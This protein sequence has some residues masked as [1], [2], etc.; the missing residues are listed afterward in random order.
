MNKIEIEKIE[1]DIKNIKEEIKK[2]NKILKKNNLLINYN[3]KRFE[4]LNSDLYKQCNDI[5]EKLEE[6][7]EYKKKQK[8]LLDKKTLIEKYLRL[9]EEQEYE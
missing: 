5:R 7:E 1:N 2:Q 4:L 8:L 3:Q 6:H 9:Q